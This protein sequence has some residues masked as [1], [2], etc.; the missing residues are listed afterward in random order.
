MENWVWS[1]F[2]PRYHTYIGNTFGYPLLDFLVF[3]GLLGGFEVFRRDEVCAGAPYE[4][5]VKGED[6]EVFFHL[7][8]LA[9]AAKA[10]EPQKALVFFIFCLIF[11][12]P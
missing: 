9:A 11:S 10:E 1:S 6:P 2:F 3:E 4:F 8:R 5:S 7:P 12:L